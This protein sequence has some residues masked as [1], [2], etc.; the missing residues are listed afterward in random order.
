MRWILYPRLLETHIGILRGDYMETI[1]EEKESRKRSEYFWH[2]YYGVS[3]EILGY[4]LLVVSLLYF[5]FMVSVA[6][7]IL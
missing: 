2:T 4:V 3:S 1:A 5:A 7:G 6:I